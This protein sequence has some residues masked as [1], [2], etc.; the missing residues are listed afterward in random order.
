[1]ESYRLPGKYD[2]NLKITSLDVN[3]YKDNNIHT[4][5]N[6]NMNNIKIQNP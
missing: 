1:M 5:P 6:N 4:I 2:C 3:K